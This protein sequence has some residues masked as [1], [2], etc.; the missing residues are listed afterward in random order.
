MLTAAERIARACRALGATETPSTSVRL[1]TAGGRTGYSACLDDAPW[2]AGSL[3]V[4]EDEALS[5]LADALTERVARFIAEDVEHGTRLLRRA[6][7]RVRAL[8][9]G[10]TCSR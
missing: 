10:A 6:D 4:D 9:G 5:L 2:G 8:M 3:G 7:A 1:V